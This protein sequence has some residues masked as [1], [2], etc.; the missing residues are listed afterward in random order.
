MSSRMPGCR[1]PGRHACV[2][3]LGGHAFD[4]RRD[5]ALTTPSERVRR[6]VSRVRA[7]P[8][9]DKPSY[10][11]AC[12]RVLAQPPA[13]TIPR[14]GARYCARRR[15]VLEYGSLKGRRPPWDAQPRDEALRIIARARH[16]PDSG[17]RPGVEP[18]TARALDDGAVVAK[19]PPRGPPRTPCASPPIQSACDALS[20]GIGG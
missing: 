14:L 17:I 19:P 4:D 6:T 8:L 9:E 3:A 10:F 1:E 12:S 13:A 11:S 5:G 15:R 18:G 16:R 7:V 2:Q 20:D